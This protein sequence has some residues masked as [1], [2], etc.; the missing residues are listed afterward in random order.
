VAEG[1]ALYAEALEAH[2]LADAQAP[3]RTLARRS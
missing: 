3:D 1:L 2:R